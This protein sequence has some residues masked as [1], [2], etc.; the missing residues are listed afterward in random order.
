VLELKKRAVF[1]VFIFDC[2]QATKL[3]FAGKWA[4]L[5][6]DLRKKAERKAVL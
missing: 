5:R 6:L 2:V 3:A 1:R 4:A